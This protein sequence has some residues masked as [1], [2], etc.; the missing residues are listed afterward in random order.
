MSKILPAPPI[1]FDSSVPPFPFCSVGFATSLVIF[2][3]YYVTLPHLWQC[4]ACQK[5]LRGG[6]GKRGPITSPL[7]QNLMRESSS[8]C[9]P[10]CR[11]GL[12]SL[13]K[14][15]PTYILVLS[16]AGEKHYFGLC[17]EIK[18]YMI[19]CTESNSSTHNR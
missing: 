14:V 9:L 6:K 10:Y 4:K 15:W 19:A 12:W 7:F 8:S 1:L 16:L 13:Y 5:K 2:R 3:C 17:L 18:F 11:I